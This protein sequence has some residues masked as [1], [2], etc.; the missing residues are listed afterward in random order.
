MPVSPSWYLMSRSLGL[1]LKRGYAQTWLVLGKEDDKATQDAARG[2]G[3]GITANPGLGEAGHRRGWQPK[4][5]PPL[6][7]ALLLSAQPQASGSPEHPL[8]TAPHSGQSCDSGG[9]DSHTAPELP[10]ASHSASI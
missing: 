10:E 8:N 6:H 2:E 5:A 3:S 4:A 7:P 1:P 9:T